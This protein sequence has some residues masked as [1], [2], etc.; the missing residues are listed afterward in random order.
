MLFLVP[1]AGVIYQAS[2]MK[3][4]ARAGFF[5]QLF[6]VGV[7]LLI[8]SFSVLAYFLCIA[9]SP[10]PKFMRKANREYRAK[11]KSLS[12]VNA[13]LIAM[14]YLLQLHRFSGEDFKKML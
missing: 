7:P 5:L 3:E 4:G 2:I 13:T 1:I 8:I 11:D 12:F 10:C 6:V 14:Y 9:K